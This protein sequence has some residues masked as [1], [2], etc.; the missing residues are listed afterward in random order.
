MECGGDEMELDHYQEHN[1]R[2]Y[3]V[4]FNQKIILCEFCDVDFGS[5]DP[6]HFGFEKG[7]RVGHKDFNFVK[8]ITEKQ[9]RLDKFCTNCKHR[10]PFLNFINKCRTENKNGTQQ[11]I[12]LIAR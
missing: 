10:L 9:L 1:Y 5:Y 12:Y 2:E 6:A 11:R 3:E 8:D 7:K 4:Y